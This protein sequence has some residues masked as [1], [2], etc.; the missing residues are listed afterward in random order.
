MDKDDVFLKIYQD[1]TEHED[2]L[3]HQR[4]NRTLLMQG[5]LIA[6]WL[7]VLLIS[8]QVKNPVGE[9]LK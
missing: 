7:L 5:F 8:S 3:I 6:L 1:Y 4:M 2:E 9:F